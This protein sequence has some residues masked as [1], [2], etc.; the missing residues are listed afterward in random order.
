MTPDQL[1]QNIVKYVKKKKYGKEKV[2]K[3]C[4]IAEKY[5]EGQKRKS[6]EPYIIHPFAVAYYLTEY[7]ADEESIISAILHD[8]V[9]DTEYTIEEVKKDFGEEIAKLID[10]LTKFS[11]NR[12]RDAETMDRKIES[13]RKWFSVM[14]KDIRVAVIKLIDRL[15][16]METLE[17]HGDTE[18]Q[19]KIA[20]ETLDVFVK[21]ADKLGVDKLRDKLESL[22]LKHL[23][24][25]SYKTL[26]NIQKKENK[27]CKEALPSISESL[28][29]SDPDQ[30]IANIKC[31]AP[32]IL[33]MHEQEI[34]LKEELRGVLPLIFVIHTKT[35]A[36]CYRI[37][38]LIHSLWK[39]ER[40]GV[41]DYINNPD[42]NG[43]KGLHTTVIFEEGKY[44]LFKIRTAEMEKYNKYGVTE[45]C[46]SGAKNGQK[47]L[48]WL[49]HLPLVTKGAKEHSHLFWNQLQH[50][51]L[52]E[53]I[54]IHTDKDDS[55][56][57]PSHSTVLDAAF[58]SYGK[59]ALN[60]KKVFLNGI[61][62]PLY[63][64]LVVNDTTHFHLGTKIQV[65]YEWLS[66]CDTALAKSIIR[67]GLKEESEESKIKLGKKILEKEL[68]KEGKG[69]IEEIDRKTI[70][71]FCQKYNACNLD[72][73]Y[74]KIAEGDIDPYEAMA[75]TCS[76]KE[77]ISKKVK[78]YWTKLK[79][80]I[81]NKKDEANISSILDEFKIKE[82][83]FK[84]SNKTNLITTNI[85]F[86]NK[87]QERGL[88]TY[89][90][91]C[92]DI[93][94]INFLKRSEIINLAL[95]IT[96]IVLLWGIDPVVVFYA[97]KNTEFN[98][99][100]LLLIRF[101]LMFIPFGIWGLVTMIKEKTKFIPIFNK[102]I[103]LSFIGMFGISYAVYYGLVGTS[104][105]DH[106]VIHRNHMIIT[107]LYST[108][109]LFKSKKGLLPLL[110]VLIANFILLFFTP[111]W[112]WEYKLLNIVAAI[113]FSF[114]TIN[115]NLFQKTHTIRIRYNQYLA[116]I[117]LYCAITT[118]II[119]S[120]TPILELLSLMKEN[121]LLLTILTGSVVI[122]YVIMYKI[123]MKDFSKKF[124]F[125]PFTMTWIVTLIAQFYLKIPISLVSILSGVLF[126]TS[127]IYLNVNL[128]Q[129]KK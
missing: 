80:E 102:H 109:F 6:G 116:L 13:M 128:I 115:S 99:S 117:A 2:V 108:P 40:T 56:L 78:P 45:H 33:K 42:Q 9:E 75:K 70:N 77:N 14:Q 57:L 44:V 111:N 63:K 58:H 69:F 73:V 88:K 68:L 39:T 106:M 5:H 86:Q 87:N 100:D 74:K 51:I 3:A 4:K 81:N 105:L 22:C 35:E 11:K 41:R 27:I 112:D 46:F 98:P 126:S 118:T 104:P 113:F 101:W 90:Q 18:K 103:L 93:K 76:G 85:C 30:V 122:P 94:K 38:Y 121:I 43:Y 125:I 66:Y 97:L 79:I 120:G 24:P 84:R 48:S 37:L 53:S 95:M 124:L 49:R 62:V 114:Y 54:I 31:E 34:Q 20:K 7:N 67:Q 23:D 119:F 26:C 36:D 123:S 129:R 1:F 29:S 16:N 8:T 15:H 17:G 52:D 107:I 92:A 71:N 61:T 65:E 127:I 55:L 59:K 19:K 28:S 89:L 110:G 12:F 91:K 50:D 72:E 25:Q 47:L 60:L 10:G 82:Y 21:I 32:S 96:S 64:Q 83:T